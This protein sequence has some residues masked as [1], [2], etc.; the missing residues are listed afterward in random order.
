MCI[1]VC[2]LLVFKEVVP[3]LEG[4][5]CELMWE[6]DRHCFFGCEAATE[7]WYEA[8][9][10]EAEEHRTWVVLQWL[11]PMNQSH[12]NIDR[13]CTSEVRNKTW[14]LDNTEFRE[15]I[16]KCRDSFIEL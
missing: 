6:S 12:N 4:E 5:S 13:L 3:A 11:Q 2:I 9:F 14:I 15:L 10:R 8:E 16:G 1:F 7:V